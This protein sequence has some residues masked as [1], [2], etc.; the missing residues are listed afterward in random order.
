MIQRKQIDVDISGGLNTY[1]LVGNK[2]LI[3]DE[4]GTL[5]EGETDKMKSVTQS[6]GV[7]LGFSIPMGSKLKFVV[8]PT[9]KY[10]LNSVHKENAVYDYPFLFS[11][12]TGIVY[13]L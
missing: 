3:S 11:C 4:K 10:L 5:W 12:Y 1:F 6:A 13:S 9:M 2:A 7:G 8:E